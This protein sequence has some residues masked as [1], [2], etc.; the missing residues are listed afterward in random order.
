MKRI[1]LVMFVLIIAM[2]VAFATNPILA[3]GDE[4]IQENFDSGLPQVTVTLNLSSTT[5][6]HNYL[7][8]GF[9]SQKVE[10]FSDTKETANL[11]STIPLIINEDKATASISDGLFIYCKHRGNNKVTVRLNADAKMS[12]PDVAP[13]NYLGWKVELITD[14]DSS[15]VVVDSTKDI[16][17]TANETEVYSAGN[18]NW[19][20]GTAVS[21][22]IKITTANFEGEPAVDY[23]GD[24]TV[25]VT[26]S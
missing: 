20:S 12:D 1:L 9:A 23:S 6:E 15:K 21:Y 10:A 5:T 8:I 4:V 13:V 25:S 17:A 19:V 11:V 26:V 2:G 7:E 24:L 16:N 22:P 18:G 3:S 14:P